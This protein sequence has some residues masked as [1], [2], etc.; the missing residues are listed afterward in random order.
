MDFDKILISL[1]EFGTW[2]RRNN[3]LLWLPLIGSGMNVL[4]ASFSVMAPR[5]G[6]RCRTECDGPEFSWEVPG[7]SPEEMFPS[8]DR[9]SS[10][11]DPDS[12]NYCRHYK[13]VPQG[14]SCYFNTS[15]VVQ[16]HEGDD[17]VYQPFEMESTVATEN[18][19]V[20][21]QYFWTIIIDE[22]FMLGLFLG[23]TFFGVLSDARGRRLAL[24]AA[25]LT[26]AL[27]NLLGCAMSS[28]WSYGLTRLASAAGSQGVCVVG[29]T[30]VMEYSGVRERVP[31]LPW[32]TWSTLLTSYRT[33]PPSS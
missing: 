11:Y 29:M 28:A 27:S 2:Q 20:C 14:D 6:F 10:E 31:L 24:L 33:V 9:N 16:C 19:L 23:S 8:L 4:I 26:C 5:Y 17:F 25:V 13:A 21:G 15:H 12:P 32:V 1:G 22:L 7:L 30:L 18:N 3:L